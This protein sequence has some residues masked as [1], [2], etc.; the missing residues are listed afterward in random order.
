MMPTDQLRRHSLSSGDESFYPH[1]AKVNG[2]SR[3]GSQR[4]ARL[5]RSKSTSNVFDAYSRIPGTTS[6]D[7]RNIVFEQ[8][9]IATLRELADFLRTTGPPPDRPA[10]HDECFP[11]LG[12]GEPRRWSLQS[13]R[14]NRR[15]KLQRYSLQSP[16]PENVIPGTTAEGHRYIAIST[17]ALKST[18]AG[19]PWFRS[20]YPVFL[21]QSPSPPP[22]PV[23]S[24]RGWPERSSSK[25]AS[26]SGVDKEATP[27]NYINSPR[28][29]GRLVN[30]DHSRQASASEGARSKVL[31][32]RISP[33]YQLRAMFNPADEAFGQDPGS[34]MKMVGTQK[35][36]NLEQERIHTLHLAAVSSHIV[37]PTKPL[38]PGIR[39]Q[40]PPVTLD[41]RG[42]PRSPDRSSRRP[43]NILVQSSLAVPKED[44]LPESPGFPNLLANITFPCP[45]KGSRPSSPASTV[46]S[47]L[48]SQASPGSR[49]MVRPRTSSRRAC[50]STTGS[51]ASLNELLMQQRLSSRGPQA[52]RSTHVSTI[53]NLGTNT[54]EAPSGSRLP[55]ASLEHPSSLLNVALSEANNG[56]T[57]GIDSSGPSYEQPVLPSSGDGDA[58][59]RESLASQL[60]STADSSRHS[61]HTYSSSRSSSASGMSAGSKLTITAPQTRSKAMQTLGPVD[62]PKPEPGA[63]A[64]DVEYESST[65]GL[66][67]VGLTETGNRDCGEQDVE[68]QSSS[69]RLSTTSDPSTEPNPQPK[70]ILERRLARKAKVREYKMRD[71]DA[72]R[73]D[74][75]DSP[76]LGYFATN[77]AQGH[78][79]ALQRPPSSIN[80]LRR[81][82]TLSMT[83]T[84]GDASDE[85]L[86]SPDT[87]TTANLHSELLLGEE[88]RQ[89]AVSI[90]VSGTT[91]VELKMSAVITTEIEPIYPPIPHWHSSGITMSP[92]MVIADVESRPGSPTLR[93]SALARLESPSPRTMTRLKPLKISA[94]TRHKS[95]AV[96]MSRN[97][98]TG[99]IERSASGPLD[100]K[101][102][103]RSLMTMPTPPM[104]PE[105][106]LLSKRLSLPP[107]YLNCPV[108]PRDRTSLALRQEWQF[109]PEEEP[110]PEPELEEPEPEERPSES[111]LR[112]IAL[113]ERVMREK[114]QKEKE[115][116]DIVART[117][118][119]PQKST[120]YD[121]EPDPPALGQNN[122]ETLEKRLK[123]LEKNND[124]WLSA[125]KPLL[126]TMARTLDDMRADDRC[127][128]LRMSDFVIDMEAEAKRVTHS[129]RGEKDS[130]FTTVQGSATNIPGRTTKKGNHFDTFSSTPLSPVLQEFDDSPIL[131]DEA[132]LIT[133]RTSD[134]LPRKNQ[135][136]STTSQGIIGPSSAQHRSES[137]SSEA[138]QRRMLQQ[139]TI[140]DTLPKSW[141]TSAPALAETRLPSGSEKKMTV[142]Q[143]ATTKTNIQASETAIAGRAGDGEEP[144]NWTDLDLLIQEFGSMPRKSWEEREARGSVGEGVNGLN[145]IMRELMSASQ[146]S[147]EEVMNAR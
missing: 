73:V 50:T 5:P 56:L 65:A 30:K 53:A 27:G 52:D 61:T 132:A 136:T 49:P 24:R 123:R 15:L 94:H 81:P 10:T 74:V 143:P 128:S 146:L 85:P 23:S 62:L 100:T 112:S 80:S 60:T 54:V 93:F 127:H 19:G 142:A 83:T 20:Q 147:A 55:T 116:T 3:Q 12:V 121:E 129:R 70:S 6:H 66:D 39:G 91:T 84:A 122:A 17:P 114:L 72:S 119:L 22:R 134:V 14:R 130:I 16:L 98:S 102:N 18:T 42:S 96:T 40:S 133:L 46:S 124:A 118:G 139:K 125:M 97:P 36:C 103:R 131:G 108:T 87:K 101:L 13:L 105:A 99:A 58:C 126:E 144:T 38:Q 7:M 137:R 59:H 34:P 51:A 86:Q 44:L 29:T 71:L 2:L 92:I 141:D 77:I 111:R 69:L 41:N 95:H 67:D 75:I 64:E 47:I 8:A 110:E 9:D 109:P 90:Q 76:V 78:N 48:E 140:V 135:V 82:S 120:V 32:H 45:P 31:S 106:T 28:S 33:D 68:P 57:D 63:N 88:R 113:R 21:P 79:A 117:V 25:A 11:L 1:P 37:S 107:T 4:R 104:T 145:P 89:R 26:F 115:I 43:A 35:V 138:S